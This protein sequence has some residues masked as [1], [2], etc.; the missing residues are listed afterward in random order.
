M[1]P[2]RRGGEEQQEPKR[3]NTD[4]TST[5]DP[6]KETQNAQAK[7]RWVEV[8]SFREA[9]DANDH[10]IFAN[11]QDEIDQYSNQV[12]RIGRPK[13]PIPEWL[14][15]A[16]L[17]YRTI[18][19]KASLI[20]NFNDWCKSNIMR[21]QTTGPTKDSQITVR[22][23]VQYLHFRA[24]D[25]DTVQVML[26]RRVAIMDHCLM[27]DCIEEYSMK[28]KDLIKAAFRHTRNLCLNNDVCKA[29]FI[30]R[31]QIDR[32]ADERDRWYMLV[33]IFSGLRYSSFTLLANY[34][35]RIFDHALIVY[36]GQVGMKFARTGNRPIPIFCNCT[37]Q[38][39]AKYCPVHMKKKGTFP[40][41]QSRIAHMC[42][43][44]GITPHSC[45]RTMSIFCRMAVTRDLISVKLANAMLFW[46]GS[47]D[48]MLKEYSDDASNWNLGTSLPVKMFEWLA[49]Y[50]D[51][52]LQ[53]DGFYKL[54]EVLQG[55]QER[56]SKTISVQGSKNPT[57][58]GSVTARTKA[59]KAEHYEQNPQIAGGSSFNPETNLGGEMD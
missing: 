1:A 6:N 35:I 51:L 37:E 22:E 25:E 16:Y 55:L 20:N 57:G 52:L 34:S 13:R 56:E 39:G 5:G 54:T 41:S 42:E 30:Y 27:D 23:M 24:A 31:E 33:W 53:K 11:Y 19:A 46:S 50:Q 59:N 3:H 48:T 47:N 2:K 36:P 38:C 40:L 4:P 7:R 45:R 17:C 9:L 8:R 44:I 15:T 12:R 29:P 32:L 26:N 18:A 28:G 21:L 49:L 43:K 58:P 10:I 14:F